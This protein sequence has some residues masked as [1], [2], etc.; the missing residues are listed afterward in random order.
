LISGAIFKTRTDLTH[1]LLFGFSNS[2][3][4]VFRNHAEFLTPSDN[5]YCNPVIYDENKPLMAGYCS[6]ENIEKFKGSASVVVLPTGSGR[7][8]LMADNPNFRGFWKATNRLF[9][10]AIFFGDMV[11]PRGSSPGAE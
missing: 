7:F 5:P 8:I 3:L 4:A 11:N 10:N 9:M 2:E 1:P 6:E